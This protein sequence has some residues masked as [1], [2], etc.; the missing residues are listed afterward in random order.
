MLDLFRNDLARATAYAATR[1]VQ[2]LD[3]GFGGAFEAAWEAIRAR[4]SAGYEAQLRAD[5]VEER[6][7][8]YRLATGQDLPNPEVAAAFPP[9]LMERVG[10]FLPTFGER[11]PSSEA[12]ARSQTVDAYNAWAQQNGQPLYPTA[13]EIEA[14]VLRRRLSAYQESQQTLAGSRTT[15]ATIGGFVGG[16]AGSLADPVVAGSMLL[17]ASWASG[18]LRTM[19]VEAGIGFGSDI[20]SQLTNLQRIRSVEPEWGASQILSQAAL[21]AAGGAIFGGAIKGIAAVWN[22]ARDTRYW[23]Q[24]AR[25]AGVAV[26]REAAA[27]PSFRARTAREASTVRQAVEQATLDLGNGRP[28]TVTPAAAGVVGARPGAV[29]DSDGNAIDVLYE[30]VPLRTLIASHDDSFRINP[31]Y[32]PSLQ[33][34]QR[35]RKASADQLTEI[36][37]KWEPARF[38]PGPA[39]E[40]GPMIV[41]ADNMVESGNMRTIA[42]T[43]VY[44]EGG[45]RLARYQRFLEEQGFDV[46][47]IDQPVLIARRTTQMEA[48]QRVRMTEALNRS[49]VA[50][51]SPTE[52]AVASARVID[53]EMLARYQGGDVGS[54]ANREFARA[55]LKQF[56]SSFRA[57]MWDSTG[58][59]SKDGVKLLEAALLARAFGDKDILNR[60]LETRDDNIKA[61]GGALSD[62]AAA[63]AKM[64][65][66]VAAGD[67]PRGMDTTQDITEAVK[68]VMRARDERRPVAEFLNQGE[69]FGG[70]SEIGKFFL[71]GM[72]MPETATRGPMTRQA[73]RSSIADMI[74][75]YANKARQERTSGL[76]DTGSRSADDVLRDVLAARGTPD[77]FQE[78]VERTTPEATAK[79]ADDPAVEEAVIRAGADLAMAVRPR[80]GDP[81]AETVVKGEDGRP[82]TLYHGTSSSH[83][84]FDL[85][86]LQSGTGD[87]ADS[88]IGFMFATDRRAASVFARGMGPRPSK[89]GRVMEININVRR[90]LRLDLG[91]EKYTEARFFEAATAAVGRDASGNAYVDARGEGARLRQRLIDEGY[92]AIEVDNFQFGKVSKSVEKAIGGQ[93]EPG[94][95]FYIVLDPAQIRRASEAPQTTGAL[96]TVPVLR[97]D[98]TWEERLLD[99]V[100]AEADAEIAAAKDIEACATGKPVPSQTG[101]DF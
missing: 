23:P 84:K 50:R 79:L 20:V 101:M 51:M 69:M 7:E 47:G 68:M 85:K 34:R 93:V 48:G 3:P 87:F 44:A 16:M 65:D 25:D 64:R 52:T 30:V 94:G 6:L 91:G 28:V 5:F 99:E 8:A 59:L 9:T 18:I 95:K 45:E 72:F 15:G 82:A 56:P 55:F 74:E 22:L 32:D 100:Y 41:G 75:G 43:R 26:E 38:T 1:P 53:E 90:P 13:D 49:T 63:W 21:S 12:I 2:M 54:A 4:D 96:T 97:D 62:A 83:D 11:I 29:F 57:T 77:M 92:D 88:E 17:G 10:N 80:E 36:L 19:L 67:V 14:E 35:D 81:F 61:I 60:I 24:R 58:G 27:Q 33:P 76:F 42:L 37:A 70:L 73:S 89:T 39:G 40:T 86:A 98:G 46:N 66:A 31:L 71:R 78:I